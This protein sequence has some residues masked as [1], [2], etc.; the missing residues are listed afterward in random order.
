MQDVI[1]QLLAEGCLVDGQGH[2]VDFTNTVVFVT[3][4]AEAQPAIVASA[5]TG[6]EALLDVEGQVDAVCR[7]APL[8]RTALREI[9]GLKL[10]VLE[11]RLASR[12]IHFE[13]T[14]EVLD[15]LAGM[16]LFSG[17][18]AHGLQHAVENHLAEP[19][20]ELILAHRP[21]AGARIVAQVAEGR[22]TLEIVEDPVIST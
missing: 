4:G 17:G 15:L 2:R 19:L 10:K 14:G 8:E 16:A 12:E 6:Q 21:A 1:R 7:F 22:I 13:A 9:A 18:G 20:S 11:A 3:R 5:T